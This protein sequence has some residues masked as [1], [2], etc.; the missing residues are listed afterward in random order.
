MFLKF[1]SAVTLL[2][3]SHGPPVKS[4]H[5]SYHHSSHFLGRR[6][7]EIPESEVRDTTPSHK[8]D[9]KVAKIGQGGV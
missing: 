1:Y 4:Q 2:G 7:N 9:C 8:E 5:A 3:K 6:S